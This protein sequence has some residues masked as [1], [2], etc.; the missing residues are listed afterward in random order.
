MTLRAKSDATNKVVAAI[1]SIAQD[2]IGYVKEMAGR[3]DPEQTALVEASSILS[4][5]SG[6][7]RTRIC[8]YSL[9]IFGL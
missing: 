8:K 2:S 4:F 1:V 5:S 9:L 6:A 7:M 3:L